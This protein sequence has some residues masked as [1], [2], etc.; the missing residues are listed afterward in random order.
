[1]SKNNSL[2]NYLIQTIKLSK[3]E[4]DFVKNKLNHLELKKGD[5]LLNIGDVCSSAYFIISGSFYQYN[6]DDDFNIKVIDLY[7]KEDWMLNHRS[8][9][10]RKPSQNS[11][12]AFEDSTV[13]ELSIES[14]HELIAISPS[15]LKLGK[16]LDIANNRLEFFDQNKSADE[17]YRYI[18]TQKPMLIQKF[19]L[20]IIAS[21]LKISPETLSRVRKRIN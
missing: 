16:I 6:H 19:P 13:Y 17:K 21:Y 20:T 7:S 8:F 3:R 12:E 15:F 5:S 2:Q 9:T 11:I 4:T 14:I 1:M 18:L 10:S